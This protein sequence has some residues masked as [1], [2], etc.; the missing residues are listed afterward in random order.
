MTMERIAGA[1]T[2]GVCLALI[3]FTTAGCVT[4]ASPRA[5]R[6]T[7][8]REDQAIAEERLRRL[9]GDIESIRMEMEDLRAAVENAQAN[10]ATTTGAQISGV[11]GSVEGMQQRLSALEAAR[12]SDKKELVE[13]LTQTIKELIE[14][15][16]PAAVRQTDSRTSSGSQYGYEHVVASGENLSSIARAY[17]VSMKVIVEANGLKNADVLKV[18]QELFIPD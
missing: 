16:S 5:E 11:Q 8:L 13:R 14:S 17:G 15:S 3:L 7:Q 12:I 2:G 9:E 10:V 1:R 4:T 6:Q 18:G